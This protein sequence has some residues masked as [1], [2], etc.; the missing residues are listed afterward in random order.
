MQSPRKFFQYL[1]SKLE[2]IVSRSALDIDDCVFVSEDVISMVYVDDTLYSVFDFL[3][4]HIE[5]N[6]QF[7]TL[8]IMQKEHIKRIL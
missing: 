5:W 8:K 4:V 7:G 3:G 2:L 1:K 6:E